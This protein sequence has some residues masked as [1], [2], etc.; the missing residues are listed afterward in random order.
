M[1]KVPTVAG[2]DVLSMDG[3]GTIEFTQLVIVL[4][5]GP[6]RG[7]PVGSPSQNGM[8]W[9]GRRGVESKVKGDAGVWSGEWSGKWID[10]L[11]KE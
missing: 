6:C 3:T 5:F 1:S 10:K 4:A 8:Q 7:E 2:T 9:R 11:S